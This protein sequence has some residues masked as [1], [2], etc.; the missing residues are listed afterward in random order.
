MKRRNFIRHAG[1]ASLAF[2]GLQFMSC[3]GNSTPKKLPA[4]SSFDSKFS[5][6][7]APDLKGLFFK[8]SLAQ[9]SLNKAIRGGE[10]DPLDFAEKA[11][12]MGFSGIEYVN[13]LYK[14]SYENADNQLQAIK[15]LGKE[16]LTRSKDNGQENL[17]IMI[18]GEGDL[19]SSDKNARKE[20]VEKHH[21]WV[22]LASFLGCHSIRIN[23]FGDGSRES[24][25][26]GSIDSMSQL[27]DYAAPMNINIIVENHGGNSSDPDFVAE[28]I[29]GTQKANA[30]TLPDFGNFCL[31]REGGERWGTPCIKE[32]PDIYE[33]IQKM[34]P[35]AKG[36][37]AKS[38]AFD[39]KGDE[40]K[41]DY[42]K[43]LQVV[44][45]AN[46]TGHIGV[47]YEGEIDEV[48]GILA[49]RDLLIK[50]G[51]G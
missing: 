43:M 49:T 9:W 6:L 35:Y 29:K 2:S 11:R 27:C 45:T 12:L 26:A 39:A 25:I 28:I 42:Y 30:G 17:I 5:N 22:D 1:Y 32:Y 46:Y 34:M 23:L 13:H 48:E 3:T 19:A 7:T 37:S 50:A 33:G 8:L 51:K 16:L 38:Y 44:K 4:L 20:G 31:E 10:M 47:E 41:I 40:T 14:S 36:V 18:D 21:K 24:Q 15:G